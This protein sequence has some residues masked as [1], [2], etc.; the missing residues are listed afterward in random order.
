MR[1]GISICSNYRVGDPREG[2]RNM[3]E[4]A[5]AARYADLDSLFVGD[6]HI[7]GTAYFQNNAILGRLLAEWGGRHR[8]W[9]V[10]YAVRYRG[11][12]S[13]ERGHGCRPEKARAHV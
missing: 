7:T 4:R 2:A 12:C 13:A 3:I 6:H 8:A 10:H 9:T 5:R 11:R 1:I